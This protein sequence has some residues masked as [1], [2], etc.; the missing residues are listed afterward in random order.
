MV[1]LTEQSEAAVSNTPFVDI[2]IPVYNTRRDY[3][4]QCINSLD[5]SDGRI[6]VTIVDDGSC[7]EI[8][9]YLDEIH[10]IAPSRISVLHKENGGQGSA[11][12]MG[13]KQSRGEYLCFLD[14]DD[15][16]D[17]RQF[18]EVLD[19][20]AEYSPS[21]LSF[22][23]S[24]LD[25]S[26]KREGLKQQVSYYEQLDACD[27]VERRP[28]L[29]ASLFKRESIMC[30]DFCIGPIMGEDIVTAILVALKAG[31]VSTTSVDA[32]R[33]RRN[34]SS[35]T[36]K[37]NRKAVTDIIGSMS[38]LAEKAAEY[39]FDCD[40]LIEWISIKHVLY[41]SAIRCIDW[42]GPDRDIKNELFGFMNNKFP[43]WRANP[44]LKTDDLARAPSFRL[45]T[46]GQWRLYASIRALTN[47]KIIQ[48]IRSNAAN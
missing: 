19:L 27:Y 25:G 28:T 46:K 5:Y 45:T 42:F 35:V 31:V 21:I 14:S 9:H 7:S 40:A 18:C 32:Y 20:A 44:Y 39:A 47:S 22:D 3:I 8:A 15:W 24:E 4:E 2:I 30:E 6:H 1:D 23:Y 41:Y 26:L 29:C 13:V 17:W 48:R 12:V 10:Q 33:Y 38:F 11:R 16:F 37:H 34:D 36:K 43:D